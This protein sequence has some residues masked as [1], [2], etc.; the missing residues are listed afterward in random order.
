MSSHHYYK[1][2]SL[3]KNDRAFFIYRL[4]AFLS[5]SLM[6]LKADFFRIYIEECALSP[7]QRLKELEKLRRQL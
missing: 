1:N 2:D 5:L 3:D 4:K 6:K 7:K